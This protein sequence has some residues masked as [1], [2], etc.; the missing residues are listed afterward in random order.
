MKKNYVLPLRLTA[1]AK[2]ASVY[3]YLVTE[4]IYI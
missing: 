4:K 1:F 2:T 3:K